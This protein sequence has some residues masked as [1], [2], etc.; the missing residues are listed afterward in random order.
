M[1]TAHIAGISRLRIDT[2]GPGIFTLVPLSGCH[3]GCAYCLNEALRSEEAGD[4]YEPESLLEMVRRDDIYFMASCG[5]ITFGGG[6]PLLRSAFIRRFAEIC[7]QEW[8]IAVETSLNVPEENLMEVLD[9]VDLWF[10]DIKDMN[11]DIYRKYTGV[12][13]ENVIRNLR[14]LSSQRDKTKVTVRI[15]RI[16]GFNTPEDVAE[17]IEAIRSMGLETAPFD[18]AIPGQKKDCKLR[19]EGVGWADSH[20]GPPLMGKPGDTLIRKFMDEI[21]SDMTMGIY[22]NDEDGM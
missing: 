21:L 10:V 22:R 16:E 9:K 3:L 14:T 1:I 2:D 20:D 12:S 19:D 18:Y 6:E 4:V 11:P 7:P 15:P 8:T 13:N 5:G 17:S